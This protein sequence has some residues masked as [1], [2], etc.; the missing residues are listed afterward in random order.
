M[1]HAAPLHRPPIMQGLLKSIEKKVSF[2]RP[3][4]P[5]PDDAISECVDD[6]SSHCH[7]AMPPEGGIHA[8]NR[9]NLYNK[10]A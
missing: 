1:D 9:A 10:I 6:Q 5:P 3:L 4:C 2:G 8:I 7:I